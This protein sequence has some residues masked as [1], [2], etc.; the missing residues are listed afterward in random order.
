MWY[1]VVCEVNKNIRYFDKRMLLAS[2]LVKSAMRRTIGYGAVEDASEMIEALFRGF[3]R[4]LYILL[5]AYPT[6]CER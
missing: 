3:S 4:P 2:R 5:G 1:G 6:C